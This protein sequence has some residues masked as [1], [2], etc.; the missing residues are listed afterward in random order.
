MAQVTARV[1]NQDIATFDVGAIVSEHTGPACLFDALRQPI[2]CN[3]KWLEAGL[4]GPAGPSTPATRFLPGQLVVDLLNSSTTGRVGTSLA[5]LPVSTPETGAGDGPADTVLE[6]T[7][8]P[9]TSSGKTAS[10][11]LGADRTAMATLQN[12]L[13][14]SREFHHAFAACSADFIWQVD[15]NGVIDYTGPRGLLDYSPDEVFGSPMVRFYS[16]IKEAEASLVFHSR[17]PMWEREVWL[18][19]KSGGSHCFLVSSVPLTDRFGAWRGARGVAREVTDQRQREAELKKARTSQRMIA[20]VLHAMRSE[21]DPRAI[22][23]A[24]AIVAADSAELD[25]CLVA[26]TNGGG[27]LDWVATNLPAPRMKADFTKFSDPLLAVMSDA[28]ATAERQTT[29]FEVPMGQFLIA[30]T[31]VDGT[32]NGAVAFGRGMDGGTSRPWSPE[33]KH[34]LRAMTEQLGISLAQ[35]ELVEAL[36]QRREASHAG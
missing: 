17:E 23:N 2:Q 18:S 29:G 27:G 12:A 5:R 31:F 13:R 15:G 25:A 32:A 20:T 21:V 19:D 34:I 16:D 6:F 35:Y 11:V 4:P 24:A 9:V 10:L 26:R 28:I 1:E 3:A 8:L 36:R 14:E 22:L 30:V 7:I 33:D